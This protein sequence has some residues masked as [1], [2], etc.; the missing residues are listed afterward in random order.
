MDSMKL[1]H[2]PPG[3]RVY[4]LVCLVLVFGTLFYVI[5]G[6]FIRPIANQQVRP[7]RAAIID[8]LSGTIPNPVFVND[9]AA[10][11]VAAGFKVDY[12]GPNQVTVALL[13][14]L[15]LMGY[16]LVIFRDHSTGGTGDPV[17]ILTSEPYSAG[18]YRLEQ[19]TGQLA[20]AIV[21]TSV[22]DYFAITPEFVRVAMQGAFS[23][24]IILMMGCTGL[25]N[26]EMA[27]A[28]VAKGA[29]VYVSW[30]QVIHAWRTDLAIVSLLKSLVAGR[31][32]DTAVTTA[33]NNIPPD[34]IYNS[35]LAYYPLTQAGL[36]LTEQS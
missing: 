13:A 5:E 3:R 6:P 34:P 17:S 30:E 31:T 36:R 14:H 10:Q 22:A 33:T 25:A 1:E 11:L 2:A 9:A 28:F 29:A 16:G 12:Y 23:S 26:S 19:L 15:P 7:A 32:L 21:S 20:R 27:T 24:T 18:E 8:E 35:Q 4:A